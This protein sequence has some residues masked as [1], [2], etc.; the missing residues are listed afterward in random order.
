MCIRDS[1]TATLTYTANNPEDAEYSGV[2][3]ATYQLPEPEPESSGLEPW[4][5]VAIAA[6]SLVVLAVL[7]T[8]ILFLL[9]K[10]RKKKK[11]AA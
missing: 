11:Q 9:A 7:I 2:A 5:I 1:Y 4:Q 10:K 8:A 3:Y 6:G